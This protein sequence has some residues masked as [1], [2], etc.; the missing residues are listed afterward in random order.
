M[1]KLT[2]AFASLFIGAVLFVSCK[3]D[4]GPQGPQ[5]T[6]GPQGATGATGPMG[7]SGPVGATGATG[8]TGPQ[9]PQGPAGPSGANSVVYS[10]W[11]TGTWAAATSGATNGRSS[12]TFSRSAPSLTQAVIDQGTVLGYMRGST[13]SQIL[14]NPTTV[15]NL[16]YHDMIFDDHIK[17]FYTA[18][19]TIVHG[20]QSSAAWTPTQL[21][22]FN[23]SFRYIIIP[24]SIAGGRLV[25]G[26][27]AGYT[28]D[29]VKAMSY[30]QIASMLKIPFEGSNER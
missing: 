8:A 10:S 15:V 28:V 27:A 12:A 13:T 19:Q 6:Q 14:S 26:P 9:G 4:A 23:H 20:Y 21:N 17:M 7:P 3:G 2:F 24:G 18:P 5:G 29:Q 22:N 30:D 1:R 11:Y 25:S 16:P